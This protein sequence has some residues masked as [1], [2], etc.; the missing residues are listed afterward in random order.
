MIFL[1]CLQA[2]QFYQDIDT[3]A[4]IELSCDNSTEECIPSLVSKRHNCPFQESRYS[5][6][7]SSVLR[8]HRGDFDGYTRLQHVGDGLMN[9]WLTNK[10][11]WTPPLH[12]N[13]AEQ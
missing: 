9:M 4:A 7:T 10:P 2:A 12:R 13:R 1:P 5:G 3:G 11:K 8:L 6:A